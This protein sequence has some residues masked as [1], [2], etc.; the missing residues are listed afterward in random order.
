M[1]KRKDLSEFDQ[2][3]QIVMARPM[4]QNISKSAALVGCS[5]SAVVFFLLGSLC[6]SEISCLNED[7]Q[8]VDWFIIYKLPKYKQGSVG[9]GVDYMY[10]D[11]SLPN[12][13]MSKYAVNTTDGALGRTLNQLYQRYESNSSVYIL[14]NDAPPVLKYQTKYGHSKAQQLAYVNPYTYNCSIPSAYYTEMPEMAHICAGKTVTVVPRRRLEKLISVKGETFLSFA[15]SHHYVDDIYTGWIAQALK[16][17]FLVESWQRDTYQLPSNCS[18][19]YHVMNIKM[20]CLFKLVTFK[21][22]EDHSKWCVSWEN[23]NQW[24]CLGDLNRES[25]QAWRGGGLICTQNSVIYKAFRS[26][27]AWYK[28]CQ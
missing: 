27:V 18:L 2:K 17:D 12:W 21:S 13:H 4:D 19:P 23:Q 7:G 3:D 24:T 14:Y 25:S 20:V 28:N 11:P 22:Y 9:S 10:L 8:P 1:D 16:A 26:A 15:K 5:R 6:E